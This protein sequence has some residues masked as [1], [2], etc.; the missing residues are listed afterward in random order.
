MTLGQISNGRFTLGIGTGGYGSAHWSSLGLP[1]K[2]I[3]IMREH[4]H[5]LRGLMSGETVTFEGEAVRL[6]EARLPSGSPVPLHLAALGPQML[7]VA[8]ELADGVQ[9]LWATRPEIDRSRELVAEAAKGAGRR[10][11]DVKLAMSIWVCIDDDLPGARR[12]LGS[13]ILTF[14]LPRPGV[15]LTLGYRGHFGRMG[16]ED[17]LVDLERRRAAGEPTT[18][19]I[20][21]LP[22]EMLS[23]FGYW[24]SPAGAPAQFARLAQGLDVA[25]V[26]VITTRPGLEGVARTISALTPD[27]IGA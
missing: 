25:T 7:R 8:G 27:L 2:P 4:L 3:T 19:L 23:A 18:A 22:D 11:E 16:F 20:D 24:G 21:A 15:P 5:V 9:L 17:L 6:K 13:R 12:A 1:N 10:P 26:R 14:A